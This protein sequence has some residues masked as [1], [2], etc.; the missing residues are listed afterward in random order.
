VLRLA[1][2]GSAVAAQPVAAGG[3][4]LVATKSGGLFAFRLE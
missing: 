2:D 1:T 3:T 4:F